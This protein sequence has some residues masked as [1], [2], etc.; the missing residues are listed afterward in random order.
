MTIASSGVSRPRRLAFTV[1][2]ALLVVVFGI[3]FFGLTS[4]AIGW[5]DDLEGVAGPI[6][7]LGYGA[8]IGIIL[9]VGLASQLRHPERR[10]AGLQQATLVIPALIAGSVLA[11]DFQNAEPLIILVPAL[12]V[13]WV[14]HPARGELL[15]PVVR[16]SPLLV[17]IALVGAIP[18]IVYALN[19]GAAAKELTGPPHH[20][21]RLSWMAGL[22]VAI[23]LTALLAALRTPGWR[24]P[25]W[26]AALATGIFGVASVMFPQHPASIG[27]VWGG[28]AIAAGIIFAAAGEWEARRSV[29]D[30]DG[31]RA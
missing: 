13:L 5:F 25:T 18:L 26:S 28:L 7:E 9:T 31:N 2:T 6:T 11:M 17:V 19:M 22:A 24:I 8:L 30:R 14:L 15:R 4:L 29:A 10:V 23:E 1:W 16:I 3:A 21:Q 12:G 27:T 20:I